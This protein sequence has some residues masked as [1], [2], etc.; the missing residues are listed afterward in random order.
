MEFKQAMKKL[1]SKHP[2]CPI[3]A[4]VKLEVFPEVFVGDTVKSADI[5]K[6]METDLDSMD[7]ICEIDEIYDYIE[8]YGYRIL[9][10][11]GSGDYDQVSKANDLFVN[12]TEEF[13]F[14][15]KYNHMGDEIFIDTS[16]NPIFPKLTVGGLAKL[17][18][19]I[20]ASSYYNEDKLYFLTTKG[21]EGFDFD[22]VRKREPKY[23][24]VSTDMV[25]PVLSSILNDFSNDEVI[26]YHSLLLKG[27][28]DTGII[29]IPP[30]LHFNLDV[31]DLRQLMIHL[32]TTLK[33][34]ASTDNI[35]KAGVFDTDSYYFKDKDF[36]NKSLMMKDEEVKALY[37][38]YSFL[39]KE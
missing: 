1:S 39:A 30:H 34:G 36:P 11:C 23:I 27:M 19:K 26:A 2:N 37:N 3:D 25:L 16:D 38:K 33:Y 7:R 29:K 15:F 32:E 21:D 28:P 12:N 24:T 20:N 18:K 31:F 35:Y 10:I 17:L 22:D 4:L 6:I 9:T 5:H 13:K 14:G 8:P